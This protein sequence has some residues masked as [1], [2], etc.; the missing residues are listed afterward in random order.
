MPKQIML[1]QLPGCSLSIVEFN[2]DDGEEIFLTFAWDQRKGP[3]IRRTGK[4]PPYMR[5]NHTVNTQHDLGMRLGSWLIQADMIDAELDERRLREI[6][7]STRREQDR[8]ALNEVAKELRSMK[9]AIEAGRPGMV[10]DL[11]QIKSHDLAFRT[12]HPNYQII[13][14]QGCGDLTMNFWNVAFVNNSLGVRSDP[15]VCLLGEDLENRAYSCLV[16]WNTS[17]GGVRRVTI[18]ELEFERQIRNGHLNETV[19]LRHGDQMIPRG[20]LIEFAVSNQQVIREGEIVPIVT[21]CHQFG[22][23]RH[24]IQM[25]NLNPDFQLYPEEEPRENGSYRPRM[26]FNK[27]QHNDIWLGEAA[28]IGEAAIRENSSQNLLR[29]ALAGP[30]FLDFPPNAHP[31]RLRGALRLADYEE[32]SSPLEPLSPGKWRFVRRDRETAVLEIHFK[33]NTYSWSMIGLSSD[34][35]RILCLACTGQPG[36]TGYTLEEAAKHLLRA[37][38]WNALLIDEGND[39]FQKVRWKKDGELVDIVQPRRHRLRATFIVARRMD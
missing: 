39:V 21:S 15:L 24:L 37:G 36:K 17:E 3:E 26:Y 10:S 12:K 4:G 9:K 23:L 1:S 25:P 18:E 34:N 2:L 6:I 20:D 30:I 28:F 33:R 27:E 31:D 11:N 19:R 32:V 35:R 5:L 13:G 16:K 8:R 14:Q 38:A 29:A 7:S 22:D